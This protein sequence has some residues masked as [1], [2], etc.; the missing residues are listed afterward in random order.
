MLRGQKWLQGYFASKVERK[1]RD[2]AELR[3]R[4]HVRWC[5]GKLIKDYW[6]GVDKINNNVKVSC[7]GEKLI[8]LRKK[9]TLFSSQIEDYNTGTASQKVL[10]TVPLVRTPGTVI[11]FCFC[12]VL[13]CT[14]NDR[15]HNP[16]LSRTVAPTRSQRNECHLLSCL[17]DSRRILLFIIGRVFLL[18]R[19][20]W[21]TH[22]A[23]HNAQ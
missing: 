6:H 19:E 7:V 9:W 22:N 2:R 17:A 5:P 1:G 15:L 3:G 16:D 8:N 4:L 21:S 11:Y 18:M 12:F 23:E 13:I 20:D 10:R 14:L